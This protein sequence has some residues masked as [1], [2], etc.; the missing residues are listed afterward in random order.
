[1]RYPFRPISEADVAR[2]AARDVEDLDARQIAEAFE[3]AVGAAILHLEMTP[4]HI[5]EVAQSKEKLPSQVGRDRLGRSPRSFAQRVPWAQLPP[6]LTRAPGSR[7]PRADAPSPDDTGVVYCSSC[8][9]G[10]AAGG[11][12]TGSTGDQGARGCQ[13]RGLHSRACLHNRSGRNQVRFQRRMGRNRAFFRCN[14]RR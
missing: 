2:H 5:A 1:M 9:S 4:V 11:C 7:S 10:G 6:G 3:L 13:A 8:G 12:G 14:I